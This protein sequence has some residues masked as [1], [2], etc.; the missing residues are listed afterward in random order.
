MM[1]RR[2]SI[3]SGKSLNSVADNDT[4]LDHFGTIGKFEKQPFKSVPFIIKVLRLNSPEWLYM[5]IGGIAALV[6]GGVIPVGH[7]F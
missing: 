1:R 5:I 4:S 6:F 2:S 3:I 7:Y